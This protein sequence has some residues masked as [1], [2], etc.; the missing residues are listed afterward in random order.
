[1][2]PK[3]VILIDDDQDDLDVMKD[4]VSQVDSTIL[5]HTFVY[6]EE[7]LRLLTN[8]LSTIPDYIFIDINMPRI[9]GDV[10]LQKI[11]SIKELEYVPITIYSTSLSE[12]KAAN[13]LALGATF[14]FEK[15][16]SLSGYVRLLEQILP[17]DTLPYRHLKP[18][19]L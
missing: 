19:T 12:N 2:K 13:L 18:N 15:P 10:C 8:E 7:A 9:T 5:C 17:G 16:Y 11:R 4:A 1:M 14:T 3:T 6:A